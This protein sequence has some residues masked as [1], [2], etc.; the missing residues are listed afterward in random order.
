MT[1]QPLP[2]RLT[3]TADELAEAL[4]ISVSTVR[5]RCERG[6]ID[7]TKHGRFWRISRREYARLVGE[8]GPGHEANAGDAEAKRRMR[9]LREAETLLEDA[10]TAVRRALGD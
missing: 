3:Y 5:G 1:A 6:E 4:R 9:A 7:A 8:E 10:L 2:Q